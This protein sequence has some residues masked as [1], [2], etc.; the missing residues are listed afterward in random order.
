MTPDAYIYSRLAAHAGLVAL[1]GTRISAGIAE[2]GCERPYLT[3]QMFG[4]RP[5]YTHDG[6]EDLRDPEFQFDSIADTYDGAWDVNAQLMAA[7]EASDSPLVDAYIL[8]LDDGTYSY[9][10][11]T[12]RHR[13]MARAAVWF[14]KQ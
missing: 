4:A 12:G 14:R 1:V 3:Y 13:V 2:Q 10:E 5:E 8:I 11:E 9:E 7:L 6:P